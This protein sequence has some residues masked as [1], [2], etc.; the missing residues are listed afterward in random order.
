MAI[1]SKK[2][3]SQNWLDNCKDNIINQRITICNYWCSEGNVSTNLSVNNDLLEVHKDNGTEIIGKILAWGKSNSFSPILNPNLSSITIED[4]YGIE[5]VNNCIQIGQSSR[6]VASLNGTHN[7]HQSNLLNGI[8]H[9]WSL[10]DFR[11]EINDS[12]SSE[13]GYTT[14]SPFAYLLFEPFAI[15]YNN[16]KDVDKICKIKDFN[17]MNQNTIKEYNI[18][19]NVRG[20]IILPNKKR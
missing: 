2:T 15:A 8:N 20:S 1:I 5:I 19:I 3:K 7:D 17:K 12:L 14:T 13:I 18:N 10:H 16:E 4:V 11:D 9:Q 6:V